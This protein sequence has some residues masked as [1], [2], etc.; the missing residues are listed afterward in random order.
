MSMNKLCGLLLLALPLAV[1]AGEDDPS[2]C[3]G[4]CTVSTQTVIHLNAVM[5]ANINEYQYNCAPNFCISRSYPNGVDPYSNAPFG[6]PE[7]A[8]ELGRDEGF[9]T[10]YVP[11]AIPAVIGNKPQKL[12]RIRFCYRT[13]G[14]QTHVDKLRV[15]A[16]GDDLVDRV[17]FEDDTDLGGGPAQCRVSV[18][19]EPLPLN[20]AIHLEFMLHFGPPEIERGIQ[21]GKISL[22]LVE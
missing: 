19:K 7:V 4:A 21:L 12:Q 15:Y 17:I 9:W 13:T 3:T 2:S 6:S 20:D 10:W 18:P 11:V 8:W 1:P 16:N 22:T 14:E 5:E